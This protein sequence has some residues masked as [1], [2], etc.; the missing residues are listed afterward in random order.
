[1]QDQPPTDDQA[2]AG[3]DPQ[4]QAALDKAQKRLDETSELRQKTEQEAARIGAEAK[5]AGDKA[6]QMMGELETK[7]AQ[8]DKDMDKVLLDNFTPPAEED[9]P[10]QDE[11]DDEDEAE[12]TD[13][14][15]K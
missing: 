13:S 9:E 3:T 6:S 10:V 2:P 11:E 5:A 7:A 4:V 15:E 12:N 8:A 1:M 14:V